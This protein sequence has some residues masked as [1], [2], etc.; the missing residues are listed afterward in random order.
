MRRFAG[1]GSCTRRWALHG[2]AMH[3]RKSALASIIA[4]A[5]ILLACGIARASTVQMNTISGLSTTGGPFIATVQPGGSVGQYVAGQ[6]FTTFCVEVNE[7][8][9][10]GG[11]YT[12]VVSAQ[13]VFGGGSSKLVNGTNQYGSTGYVP[14]QAEV[15]YLYSNYMAG[16]MSSVLGGW[17]NDAAHSQSMQNAIWHFMGYTYQDGNTS[18]T[19]GLEAAANNAVNVT[20]AWSG[21]GNV[22][23]MQLWTDPTLRT[24]DTKAQDQLVLV[25]PP[26][27][28]PTPLGFLGGLGLLA[29]MGSV[30]WCKR[31]IHFGS[32]EH[33]LTTS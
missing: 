11:T 9:Y 10:P 24:I 12:P 3:I 28:V 14:L 17:T 23:V 19:S 6:S 13:S 21:L 16:T 30:G 25:S 5:A 33:L 15:A 2:K 18:Y 4:A 32:N 8:F 1:L 27:P 29:G 20:H 22:R 7:E 31:R 26:V